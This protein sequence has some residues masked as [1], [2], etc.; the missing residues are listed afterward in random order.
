MELIKRIKAPTPKFWKRVRNFCG[1]LSTIGI[2][3]MASGALTEAQFESVKLGTIIA[4]TIAGTA[5]ITKEDESDSA[6]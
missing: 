3:L 5:Q 2:T 4:G 6:K 1:V